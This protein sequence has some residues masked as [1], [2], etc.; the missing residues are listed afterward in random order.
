MLPQNFINILKNK[1]IYLI[2]ILLI[3]SIFPKIFIQFSLDKIGHDYSALIPALFEY[4]YFRYN[5]NFYSIYLYSP[6]LCGVIPAFA[7]PNNAFFAF[8]NIFW[9]VDNF[10]LFQILVYLFST[11][12]T[13]IYSYKICRICG[14]SFYEGLISA[15][16][17]SFSEFFFIKILVG[18]LKYLYFCFFPV[19]CYYFL[20]TNKIFDINLVISILLS[21][22][23]IYGG[24]GDL[25]PFLIYSLVLLLLILNYLNKKINLKNYFIK[26]F[27]YL[28][29]VIGLSLFK[30]IPSLL[31][32]SNFNRTEYS[33]KLIFENFLLF[34]NSVYI[35]SFFAFFQNIDTRLSN[36]STI[37]TW[38][39]SLGLG[40]SGLILFILGFFNIKYFINRKRLII[41]FF[42]FIPFLL[43]IQNPLYPILMSN[44]PFNFYSHY[45]RY[46]FSYFPLF[47]YTYALGVNYILKLKSKK[48][49]YTLFIFIS[50]IF[51]FDKYYL[52]KWQ[53]KSDIFWDK[54]IAN[55][56][57]RKSEM[58]YNKNHFFIDK[59]IVQE[60]YNLKNTG[61][62]DNSCVINCYE[63]IFGYNSEKLP[64][65]NLQLGNIENINN[66]K[67]N[68]LNPDCFL[69]YNFYDCKPG[70]V[71]G[72][73][74]YEK[75][76]NIRSFKSIKLSDSK[77]YF[78][79]FLLSICFLIILF[80]II[81]YE[82][83]HSRHT[84]I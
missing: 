30:I 2:I 54:I 76:H 29:F 35:N 66:N 15:I 9:Y 16:V 33:S 19:I 18:H 77:I 52:P 1:Y 38:E 55:D 50:I 5:N 37:G 71:Y 53:N 59:L 60:N 27:I 21:T 78:Y 46:L 64:I 24:S 4:K 69:K 58:H 44:F 17:F 48:S 22:L 11:T 47:L 82:K 49:I 83:Y 74:D 39:I 28:F 3:I 36:S 6:T 61:I 31:F 62:F 80:F 72:L 26:L 34:I 70:D 81:I 12:L 32:L 45:Q 10:K 41:I 68:I 20:I 79:S 40:L 7:N 8:Y 73:D 63:S 14:F 25:L 51:L 42:I 13:L 84:N 57:I 43:L 56:I 75:V 65:K 23:I 67:F